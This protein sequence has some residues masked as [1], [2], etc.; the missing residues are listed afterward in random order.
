MKV[1]SLK[2][3]R[4]A[5][6]V[7]RWPNLSLKHRNVNPGLVWAFAW[8]IIARSFEEL[9]YD[10]RLTEVLGGSHGNHS[11]HY[12]GLG[13]DLEMQHLKADDRVAVAMMLNDRL[14]P[15]FDI[16]MEESHFHIEYD[17]KD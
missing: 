4:R 8:P 13:I 10:C 17:P 3:W 14:G 6:G 2:G 11:L 7:V 5:D 15:D 9:G 16:V 1:W 12:D